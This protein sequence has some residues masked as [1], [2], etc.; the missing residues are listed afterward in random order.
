MTE[1]KMKILSRRERQRQNDLKRSVDRDQKTRCR[2][3]ELEYEDEYEPIVWSQSH[4]DSDF[5]QDWPRMKEWIE[6][7]AFNDW[8]LLNY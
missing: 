7:E 5:L 8:M 1:Y 2:D 6:L 3:Y 4:I